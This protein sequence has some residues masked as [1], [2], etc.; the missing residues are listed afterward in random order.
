MKS[1]AAVV[2]EID[3]QVS[4]VAKQAE[5]TSATITHLENVFKEFEE[6]KGKLPRKQP[7]PKIEALYGIIQDTAILLEGITSLIY[8]EVDK[9]VAT[10]T[11]A[12][13]NPQKRQLEHDK[14]G[15]LKLKIKNAQAHIQLYTSNIDIQ[16]TLFFGELR[17]Q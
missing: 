11:E 13:G 12:D 7:L 4:G 1:Y 8:R 5:L 2:K 9:A 10:G 15:I 16:V 17:D 3:V 6:R 14:L